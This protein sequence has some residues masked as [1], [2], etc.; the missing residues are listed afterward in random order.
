MAMT[1][2]DLLLRPH[3][4]H[5]D[6]PTG[7]DTEYDPLDYEDYPGDDPTFDLA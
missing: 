5:F 1:T 4:A 6:G 2:F 3:L 7:G